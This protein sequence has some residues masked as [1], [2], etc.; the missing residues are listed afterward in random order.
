MILVIAQAV[1]ESEQEP[2]VA[3]DFIHRYWIFVPSGKAQTAN[4]AAANWDPD[5]GGQFTF[6]NV[7]LSASGNLP[8]THFGCDTRASDAMATIITALT[9]QQPGV[10]TYREEDGWTFDTALVNAGL[11]RIQPEFPPG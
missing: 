7:T 10:L 6:L 5:T 9:V 8:A 11:Q 2:P 4:G 1:N 3:T